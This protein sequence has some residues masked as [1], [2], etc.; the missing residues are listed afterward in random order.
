MGSCRMKLFLKKCVSFFVFSTKISYQ[1]IKREE[2]MI[3]KVVLIYCGTSLV[4]QDMR[5]E[6]CDQIQEVIKKLKGK[7]DFSQI[8]QSSDSRSIACAEMAKKELN[9]EVIQS[10]SLDQ[11]CLSKF[12]LENFLKAIT[13]QDPDRNCFLCFSSSLHVFE[14]APPISL[15][16]CRLPFGRGVVCRLNHRMSSSEILEI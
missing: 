2:K 7:F 8:I 14:M 11:D 12:T 9:L 6:E 13:G 15:D 16:D 3:K 4:G 1:K 5:P 10:S